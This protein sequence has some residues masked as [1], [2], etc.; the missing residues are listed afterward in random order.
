MKKILVIGGSNSK[1]SINTMLATYIASQIT[2]AEVTTVNWENLVLPLYSTDL[3]QAEGIPDVAIQ[4][5]KSIEKTDAIVLSLAEYNGMITSA[6]KNLW[7]W[8]SRI[9]QKIWSNKPMFLAATSPGGRGGIGAL[10]AVINIM[11][12]FGGNVI[13]DYSLPKFYQNFQDEKIL[14][15]E[16]QQE[17]TEKINLFTQA[18][19]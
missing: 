12:H 14:D 2:D 19:H 17:L 9:D 11:P 5:M 8:T 13:T 10:T 3:E 18:I 4:F 15:V 7:D 6:L 16:K 1:S